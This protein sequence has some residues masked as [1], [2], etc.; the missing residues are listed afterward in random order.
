[1]AGPAHVHVYASVPTTVLP[2]GQRQGHRRSAAKIL[3]GMEWCKGAKDHKGAKVCFL[4]I[5]AAPSGT[6][7]L[8][9]MADR[10]TAPTHSGASANIFIV[11]EGAI[12]NSLEMFQ[13]YLF[14]FFFTCGCQPSQVS[15]GNSEIVSPN[16]R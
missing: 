10:A 5:Y 2:A 7:L 16:L 13:N 1:M 4:R 12:G 11:H 14:F 9:V 15:E 3:S 6:T 8:F